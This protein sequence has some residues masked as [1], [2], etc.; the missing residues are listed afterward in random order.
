MC[1]D[2]AS[3]SAT[4]CIQ[5][6]V[7]VRVD[8][9]AL[10]RIK[11]SCEWCPRKLHRWVSICKFH[12]FARFTFDRWKQCKSFGFAFEYA[13]MHAEDTRARPAKRWQQQ[14]AFNWFL[15]NYLFCAIRFALANPKALQFTRS[16]VTLFTF[17]VFTF[18]VISS[19]MVVPMHT[20]H[21]GPT[22]VCRC[23]NR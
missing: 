9:S 17:F 18:R 16:P 19:R 15:S 2:T 7:S 12:F 6:I 1:A 23:R 4:N 11:W 13:K 22:D 10:N 5:L 3:V 20:M 8:G 21:T 14:R